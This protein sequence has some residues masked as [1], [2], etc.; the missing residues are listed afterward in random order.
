MKSHYDGE[1]VHRAHDDI[2]YSMLEDVQPERLF[3]STNGGQV[4][5]CDYTELE[6]ILN[7]GLLMIEEFVSCPEMISP[8][9][10]LQDQYL[11]IDDDDFDALSV[12]HAELDANDD[13]FHF[14]D[15]MVSP[16]GSYIMGSDLEAIFGL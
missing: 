13:C 2:S 6:S 12:L 16:I 9:Q 8:N 1:M 3:E 10:L 5:Y 11:L 15:K 7:H 14:F 4:D